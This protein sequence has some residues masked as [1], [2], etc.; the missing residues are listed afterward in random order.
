M[1]T[2]LII[3]MLGAAGAQNKITQDQLKNVN[4]KRPDLKR[5]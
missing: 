4:E 1:S 5:E 3:L 2:L